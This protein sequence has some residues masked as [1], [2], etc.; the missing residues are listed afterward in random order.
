MELV[1]EVK[2]DFGKDYIEEEDGTFIEL[3]EFKEI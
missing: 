1:R 3:S 2:D